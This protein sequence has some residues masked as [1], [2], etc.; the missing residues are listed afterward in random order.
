MTIRI[1]RPFHVCRT[2]KSLALRSGD[3]PAVPAAPVG[4]VP[5]VA[6]LMALAIH[7]EEL[8]QSGD[9]ADYATLAR[10]GHVTRA[11]I[12]QIMNLLTLAPDIQEGILFLPPIIKGRDAI[13]LLQLQPIALTLSWP[14]QRTMWQALRDRL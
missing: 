2:G 12:S 6:R 13:H 3:A 11:R 7:F 8:V 9:V 10:L 14:R 1:E 5:R 4:R